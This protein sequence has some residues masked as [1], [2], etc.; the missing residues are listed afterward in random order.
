MRFAGGCRRASDSLAFSPDSTRLVSAASDTLARVWDAGTGK[1][2]APAMRHSTFVR[3]ATFAPD[4]RLVVTLDDHHARLWDSA[5]GDL[6][7]PPLPHQLGGQAEVW[8][9]RDGRRIVGLAPGGAAQQWDL[10]TFRTPTD[11]VI[12]KRAARS[13]AELARAGRRTRV[14]RRQGFEACHDPRRSGRIYCRSDR[15]LC[16]GSP[17]RRRRRVLIDR[18]IKIRKKTRH[19]RYAQCDFQTIIDLR[20]CRWRDKANPLHDEPL[21]EGEKALT[22]HYG[23]REQSGSRFQRGINDKARCADPFGIAGD[24]C[25]DRVDRRHRVPEHH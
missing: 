8:V 20:H 22:S 21:M 23:H 7:T 9:S 19:S 11:R 12:W 24:Q 3:R 14:D 13:T 18:R 4:G 2:I 1:P 16:M 17:I 25:D 15:Q 5:T 10:P 6:L